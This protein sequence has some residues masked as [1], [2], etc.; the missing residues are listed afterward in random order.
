MILAEQLGLLKAEVFQSRSNL[1][2]LRL[3]DR[4]VLS[5]YD[6][7]KEADRIAQA[8]SA[9]SVLVVGVG[10]GYLAQAFGGR[11]KR[12]IGI[13]GEWDR[14]Q[15]SRD[16]EAI[17]QISGK[18]AWC[19][20]AIE[21]DR[22]VAAAAAAGDEIVCDP[23]LALAPGLAESLAALI[24]NVR[25]RPRITIV[26]LCTAGDVIRTMPA[27]QAYR[28]EHPGIEIEFVT[29]KPYGEIL[30]VSEG[31]DVVTEIEKGS[32]TV[33][34]TRRPVIA[35]NLRSCPDSVAILQSLNPVWA[36]GYRDE[37]GEF[38][39]CDD[40]APQRV[41][42]LRAVRNRMNRYHLYFAIMGLEFSFDLPVW[43]LPAWAPQRPAYRVAQF[44]A[45]SG[46]D[47][48]AGKRLDPA[49]IGEALRRLGGKWI[50]VGSPEERARAAAGGI[51]DEDNLCGRTTWGELGRL[52]V[53]AEMFVGHDSGPAHFAAQLGVPTLSLFGFTSP[54]L[55]APIGPRAL[56]VQADMPC[57]FYGC[58]I[59]CP[60]MTCL[61]NYTPDLIVE[62]VRHLE[63][64]DPAPRLRT[65]A[66]IR[67]RGARIFVPRINPEELDPLTSFLAE[68]PALGAPRD[69]SLAL[70]KEWM[71]TR[72]R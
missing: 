24:E 29:Q 31:V 5:A 38:L 59:P 10:L 35:F 17:A 71:E 16:E 9:R 32:V 57:A 67:E 62:S 61:A 3:G 19:R 21:I 13:E 64:T 34:F 33:P 8:I 39:L 65:A 54:I 1:P 56:I 22:A 11:V 70:A 28:R 69:H 41:P 43:K 26:H 14:F 7:K 47:V 63:A 53:G 42:E 27:L 23:S 12:I 6:P 66:A 37:G 20:E 25:S 44:G 51:A 52:L 50:A 36:A 45:G 18:V 46:A 55:N 4:A 72:E 58:R 49:V 30:A 48:W 60:E 68:E 15:T 40:R 2:S